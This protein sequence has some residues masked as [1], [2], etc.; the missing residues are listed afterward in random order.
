MRSGISLTFIVMELQELGQELGQEL[1][2]SSESL[3]ESLMSAG[4]NSLSRFDYIFDLHCL[5]N[6]G[7]AGESNK[8]KKRHTG[9]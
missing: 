2:W 6:C 5:W 9:L 3:V 7:R 4:M 8:V 1:K